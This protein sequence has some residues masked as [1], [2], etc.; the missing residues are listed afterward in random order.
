MDSSSRFRPLFLIGEY[1]VSLDE[2]HRLLIPSD[3]RKEITDARDEKVLICT[4]GRN[5]VARFFPEN[6][7]RELL[8]RRRTTVAT[9]EAE[10]GFRQAYLGMVF[11]LPWDQQGRVVIPE[12]IINRTGLGRSLTLVGNGDYLEV[13]NRDAWEQRAQELIASLG[14]IHD[15]QQQSDAPPPPQQL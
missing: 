5:K 1:D 11:R 14:E 9:G 8:A 7:Y 3:F 13:W 2:K 15:Q 4:V 10:E 12:K 6:L